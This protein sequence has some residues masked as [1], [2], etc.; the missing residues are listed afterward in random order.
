MSTKK[1]IHFDPK[2]IEE[3]RVCTPWMLNTPYSVKLLS[4]L[5]WTEAFR[6]TRNCSKP[7]STR[8]GHSLLQRF[9][10]GT[11]EYTFSSW[12]WTHTFSVTQ[13]CASKWIQD[14]NIHSKKQWIPNWTRKLRHTHTTHTHTN[15]KCWYDVRY[16]HCKFLNFHRLNYKFEQTR[17][18]WTPRHPR[19][20]NQFPQSEWEVFKDSYAHLNSGYTQ[21]PWNSCYSW[22]FLKIN[23]IRSLWHYGYYTHS[24]AYANTHTHK[25]THTHTLSCPRNMRRH[26]HNNWNPGVAQICGHSHVSKP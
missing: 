8:K 18:H 15:T 11:K 25:H 10:G 9:S 4:T 6:N 16:W 7:W 3:H 17:S 20:L 21:S 24:Y 13:G 5:L 1:L 22:I 2:T 19:A 26:K 14:L 23:E 12:N